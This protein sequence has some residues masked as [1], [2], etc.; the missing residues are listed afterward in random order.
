MDEMQGASKLLN[1]VHSGKK[2]HPEGVSSWEKR[3]A[4]WQ[5]GREETG[6][7][8]AMDL[9]TILKGA[10]EM[11]VVI[12]ITQ[13]WG[14]PNWHVRQDWNKQTKEMLCCAVHS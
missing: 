1:T 10:R 2:M 3:Q 5:G 14:K 4:A 9:T 12:L 13:K 7:G 11:S 8:A 6:G